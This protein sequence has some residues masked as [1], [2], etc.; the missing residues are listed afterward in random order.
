MAL[1]GED[2]AARTLLR[3]AR[4]DQVAARAVAEAAAGYTAPE[5]TG[6]GRR[7][8]RDLL[9]IGGG[10]AMLALGADW[11][12]SDASWKACKSSAWDEDWRAGVQ[13]FFLDSATKLGDD[14]YKNR[15]YRA[16]GACRV[17]TV[18]QRVISAT[19]A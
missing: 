12:V 17:P 2:A 18:A 14:F 10:L 5:D 3:E 6:R 15:W 9:L 11:L 4:R 13:L 19:S 7:V 8:A 16:L 1:T